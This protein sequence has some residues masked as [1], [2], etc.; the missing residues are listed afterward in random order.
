MVTN[1]KSMVAQIRISY[2]RTERGHLTVDKS[3][4]AGEMVFDANTGD[5]WYTPTGIGDRIAEIRDRCEDERRA[6]YE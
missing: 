5:V 3:E 6:R 2:P 4:E 1:V